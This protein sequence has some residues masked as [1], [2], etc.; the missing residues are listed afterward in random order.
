MIKHGNIVVP[1]DFSACSDEALR[2][3]YKWAGL[4]GAEVYLVHVLGPVLTYTPEALSLSPVSEITAA[5]H[6]D[7]EQKLPLL[8]PPRRRM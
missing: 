8:Q 5:L 1:T 7:A 4:L 6:Q 3:A 2:R